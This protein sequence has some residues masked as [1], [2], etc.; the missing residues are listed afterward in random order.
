MG[1]VKQA[2][3]EVE[4]FVSACI[5]DGRTLNQTIRDARESKA[6]KYNPYLDDE[7]LVENKYYQFKGVW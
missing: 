7:E 2:I 5:R 4:D 6:A 3:L 1:Q